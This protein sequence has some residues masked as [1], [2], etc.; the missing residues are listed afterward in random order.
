MSDKKKFKDTTVGKL[1]FG[2][3]TVINPTL[4]NVLQ[5]VTSPKEAIS[6][7]TKSKIPTEDKIKLQTLIYEQQNKEM[8]EISNRWKADAASD[9]WLSKNVRPMVLVW[10]IVVFSFAGILDSVNSIDFQIN[11]LWN[12]T[13]EKVMMAVVLAYFGGRTTEKASSIIKGK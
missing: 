9:S 11:A 10:C 13:F 5:G 8:E 3:A 4:G 12:D 2:A 7:I 1:L 6:E